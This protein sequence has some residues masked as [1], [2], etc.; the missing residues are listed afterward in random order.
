DPE[1]ELT[2]IEGITGSGCHLTQDLAQ[3]AGGEIERAMMAVGIVA[4]AAEQRMARPGAACLALAGVVAVL[5][6]AP[7]VA[8]AAI[9]REAQCRCPLPD[10]AQAL[11]AHVPAHVRV[12]RKRRTA[13]HVAVRLDT[14]HGAPGAARRV[15]TEARAA[16]QC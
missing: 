7:E 12:G 2:V 15:V 8:R 16:A 5:A 9:A 14:N 10:V 1:F 13:L 3:P 11:L 6:V 4:G